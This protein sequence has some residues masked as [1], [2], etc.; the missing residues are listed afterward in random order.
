MMNQTPVHYNY[1][2]ISKK[3]SNLGILDG[4]FGSTNVLGMGLHVDLDRN[5]CLPFSIDQLLVKPV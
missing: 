5:G 4:I 1:W 3:A 2:F